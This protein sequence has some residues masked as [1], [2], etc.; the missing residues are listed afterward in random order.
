M[1]LARIEQHLIWG[2]AD[3]GL[4]KELVSKVS[5]EWFFFSSY[6][7]PDMLVP[8]QELSFHSAG[9]AKHKVLK[10]KSMGQKLGLA[11]Q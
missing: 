2:R 11:K 3:Y 9:A 7:S 1:S 4:P 6:L 5:W 8:F 10:A